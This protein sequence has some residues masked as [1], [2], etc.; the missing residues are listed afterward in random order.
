MILVAAMCLALAGPAAGVGPQTFDARNWLDGP[1]GMV[2]GV[3]AAEVE[4]K[5]LVVY[6]Y[7]DWCGYCR[8]FERALL[9]TEQFN[10]FLLSEAV[11][12]RVNP[13]KGARERSLA[14]HYGV[15]GYPAFFVY[16]SAS[17][18][19]IRTERYDVVDGRPEM[20]DPGRFID[21]IRSTSER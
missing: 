14:V 16:G 2:K 21:R 8:Q 7:T 18:Q 4:G 17:K 9:G 15:R 11:A 13:D 19:L 12:V 20:L 1:D 3:T 5:I 10:H 6:F